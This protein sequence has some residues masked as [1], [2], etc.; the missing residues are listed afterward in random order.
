MVLIATITKMAFLPMGVVELESTP[1]IKVL[2]YGGCTSRDAVDM[3]TDYGLELHTYIARQSLVSAFKPADPNEFD[4]DSPE[5]K[6]QRRMYE[7][8][9]ESS[10]PSTVK[11]YAAEIDLVVW[12]LMIERNG[13]AKVRSGGI[14]TRNGVPKKD[15]TPVIGGAYPFGTEG[16][17]RQWLW[18]LDKWVALLERTGLKEKTV[19]NATPWAIT[20]KHGEAIQS[21]GGM[22]A[23]FFNDKIA[24]Y[25]DAAEESGIKVARIPQSAA[26]ADPDHKWGR[27]YFHYVP[28]TYKAQLDTITAFIEPG[29]L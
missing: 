23:E 18:A 25:W 2:I 16:H 17:L 26:I 5:S 20:D 21:A 14:V 11:R 29:N 7:G 24:A 9:V 28:N 3:Y 27:A 13:V 12:D 19:L 15:G 1:M 8:D 22:T 4:F 10:L 6:F